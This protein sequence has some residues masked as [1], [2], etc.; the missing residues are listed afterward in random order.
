MISPKY[1]NTINFNLLKK[2][3]LSRS[4]NWA[5]C[6]WKLC[7]LIEI[8]HKRA[9][10]LRALRALIKFWAFIN[11][12]ILFLDFIRFDNRMF[13]STYLNKYLTI[14]LQHSLRELIL[15]SL[16]RPFIESL[17]CT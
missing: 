7:D 11:F 2:Q 5:Q 6:G 1:I 16:N 15:F 13:E 14:Q 8:I 3:N 4:L 9:I 12:P 17:K 10:S